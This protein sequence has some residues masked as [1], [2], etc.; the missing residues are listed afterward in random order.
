MSIFQV[1]TVTRLPETLGKPMMTSID[2]AEEL[3]ADPEGKNSE[4]GMTLPL[5][6]KLYLISSKSE[7][8]F[9]H[10]VVLTT[11]VRIKILIFSVFYFQ[12]K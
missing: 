1:I 7:N 10:T 9:L 12:R 4:K 11:K 8:Y 2:E 5:T 3:Y 6:I